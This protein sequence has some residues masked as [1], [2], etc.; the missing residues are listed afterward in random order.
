MIMS[1][2]F[3]F[4][5]V[6]YAVSQALMAGVRGRQ[7]MDLCAES[8]MAG[9][10]YELYQEYGLFAMRSETAAKEDLAFFLKENLPSERVQNITLTS[11]GSLTDNAVFEGQI[12]EF[13]Q[14]RMPLSLSEQYT[15]LLDQ[16]HEIEDV[17]T[18]I[19][20]E[21]SLNECIAQYAE[22]FSA[23]ITALE[24]VDAYG[25][26]CDVY[27]KGFWTEEWSRESYR[28]VIEDDPL[29]KLSAVAAWRERTE[30][31]G[32][33]SEEALEAWTELTE[34][35]KRIKPKLEKMLG[36][37]E[38]EDQKTE[39]RN[40]LSSLHIGA[41]EDKEILEILEK[42]T[43]C[44][45]HGEQALSDLL[46]QED[47]TAAGRAVELLQYRTDLY[48]AYEL[49][50][51]QNES[52]SWRK[53]WKEMQDY[54]TDLSSYVGKEE[55]IS[56][57]V[58]AE[59]PSHTLPR[60]DGSGLSMTELSQMAEQLL[61]QAPSRILDRVYT[62]E[63]ATGMFRNLREQIYIQDE[64]GKPVRS[65]RGSEKRTGVFLAEQEYLLTGYGKDLK[66]CQM[67]RLEIIG[68]RMLS[69]LWFLSTNGE[70]RDMIQSMSAVGGI[71]APGWG[72]LVLEA[73]ITAV[74]AG[75]ESLCDYE[76]LIHGGKVPI[77]KTPSSWQTDLQNLTVKTWREESQGSSQNSNTKGLPYGDY[78]KVLLYCLPKHSLN[79]RV[80]DLIQLN[81]GRW[82]GVS[83][84][85]D[86]MPV[87]FEAACTYTVNG[88]KYKA[89]GEYGFS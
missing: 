65:L 35:G 34:E 36:E 38:T 23:F 8:V 67:V 4:M 69:N 58:R 20:Q 18:V 60:T 31:F 49:H 88:R 10:V 43:A 27:V 47:E 74:W 89:K 48:V 72:N 76:T 83:V 63:Y 85:L 73:L 28:N 21:I 59:L 39:I 79:C 17:S 80:M 84:R 62:V 9:Y 87:A 37:A 29:G 64:K 19:D 11:A 32:E 55:T 15:D 13:M 16:F 5:I 56:E 2:V 42:N 12:R 33:V 81:I 41:A 78:I 44:L 14:Y 54:V 53:I 82:S 26:H 30:R 68:L 25:S 70:K 51:I 61:Q 7:V 45:D 6:I 24:G 46:D 77:L 66:N 52:A 71:I 1:A 86:Q 50:P 40:M 22:L 75:A 3:L 57:S